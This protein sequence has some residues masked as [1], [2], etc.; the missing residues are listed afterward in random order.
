MIQ[1]NLKLAFR[2]LWHNKMYTLINIGGLGIGMA[3]CM[4]ILLYV[5]HEMSYDRFHTK[6]DRI[7][8]TLMKLKMGE[9]DLQMNLFTPDFAEKVK[10]ANP[11]ILES[12]RYASDFRGTPTVKS[13][14]GRQ[15]IEH[16]FFFAD[17]ALFR[18]FTFDWLQGDAEKALE[19]PD[20]VVISKEM[21]RKYFGEANP[22][23]KTLIYNKKDVFRVTGVYDKMPENSS[24]HFD[25]IASLAAFERIQRRDNPTQNFDTAP[26]FQSWFLL[27]RASD[28]SKIEA[29]IPAVLPKSDDPIFA[30]AHYVLSPLLEMHLGNNW[31][32]FS[33]SKYISVFLSV[34]A[35]VLFLA[36]FN[37]MNLSTARASSRALEVGVRKV[38]GAGG[39]QIKAQFYGESILVSAMGF[40]I[41]LL[42][43]YLSKPLFCNLLDLKIDTHFLYSSLFISVLSALFLLSA[44]IAGSYP[45][46]MLSRFSPIQVMKGRSAIGKSGESVRRGLT[47][48]QFAI[49]TGLIVFSLGVGAQLRYMHQRNIGL[50][51]EQV[52]AVPITKNII[53]HTAAFKQDIRSLT[54]VQKVS[55]ASFALF[56]GGWDM[57]FIK[58]PGSQEDI[59]ISN[60]VVDENFLET[61][62]IQWVNAPSYPRD[63]A[64]KRQLLLNES[65]VEKLRLQNRPVG[66]HLDLGRGL[67]EIAGTVRDFNF[68]SLQSPV[69]G[70]LFEVVADTVAPRNPGGQLYVRLAPGTDVQGQ[71]SAIEQLFKKYEPDAAFDYYFLDEAFDQQHRAERRMGYLFSGFSGVAILLACLGLFGLITFAAERRTKEIGVRKV[72]GASVASIT[73]LLAKDFLKLVFV[74]IAI[75]SP[76]A[77]YFMEK[78]LADFAYRIDIQWWMFVLAGFSAVLIACLT[79][80]FQ[81]IKAALADPVKSLRNE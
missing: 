74:A 24:L 36:L 16:K 70:M 37:Y 9:N 44:L 75:A 52:M 29:T 65:G 55:M 39:S 22:L 54:G 28:K 10:A 30:S 13:E 73:G 15:F 8:S 35:L 33:N 19:A 26:L 78:W 56:Q 3:V 27:E 18:V 17:P 57:V 6:G 46:F 71:L 42:L 76:V 53:P 7:F 59:G 66:E 72:L 34:A 77:Y 49:S 38:L 40:I 68:V 51:R 2:N 32:D 43:F 67:Q 21:A 4:L 41:G 61:L 11:E 50:N 20:A 58:M 62:E 45:A 69:E 79:L 64:N 1:N 80:A 81:A 14:E 23:D 47:V 25:F 63:L 5:A 12:L 60:M 31:G 48:F